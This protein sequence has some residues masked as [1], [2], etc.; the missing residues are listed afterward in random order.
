MSDSPRRA[1]NFNAGPAALPLA[2]LERAQRELVDFDGTGMSL[3][4]HSHRGKTYEAVHYEAL[5]LLRELVGIGDDYDVLL[6]QGGARQ[7]FAMVPMNLLHAGRS[8]DYVVTGTWAKQALEEAQLL[9]TARAAADTEEDGVFTRIP[10]ALDLDPNAAYV[11]LTS[12]NTLFG[13]QWAS[14]PDTGDV[15]LIAD[16]TSDLL[17]RPI[18][19]SRFGLIYAGAQKN[20]G[21]AGV[22]VVIVRK[23]LVAGARKDIPEVFR[24][25]SHASKD[26]LWNT[27]PCFPIYML[28]NTLAVLKEMG[29][30]AAMEA[31]ATKKSSTLYDLVDAH[32]DFFRC[33]VEKASRSI[34]NVVFRLPTEDLEKQFLAEAAKRGMVGLKGHRSVGGLRASIY[35]FVEPAWVD[36]VAELMDDFRR[37]H[38]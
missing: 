31:A 7:Q 37:Q 23:D 36:A 35:N 14:Y 5:S 26:S 32:P 19:A 4:E 11:H 38:G 15:P 16:M 22:T 29:G 24:Y 27:P 18:D 20:V 1:M 10:T 33:P 12:N 13:T 2:A 21:P 34:M 28:R 6:L 25:A 30:A 17:C 8:A 3:M 9:G